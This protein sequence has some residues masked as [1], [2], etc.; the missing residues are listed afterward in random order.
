LFDRGDVEVDASLIAE[1]LRLPPDLVLPLLREGHIASRFERG[2]DDDSGKS[3]LTFVHD[4]RRLQLVVDEAGRL[5]ERSET[6]L[7]SP[8]R[9]TRSPR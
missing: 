9:H 2:V 3:R 5:L 6:V 4:R 7:A 1:G 8:A